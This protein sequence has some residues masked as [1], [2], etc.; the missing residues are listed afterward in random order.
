MTIEEYKKGKRQLEKEL[1]GMIAAKVAEYEKETGLTV[2]GIYVDM[3]VACRLDGTPWTKETN[4]SV[5]VPI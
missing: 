3:H 5:N 1:A 4:V 2:E